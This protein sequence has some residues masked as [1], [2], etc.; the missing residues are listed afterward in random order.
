LKE[1]SPA[2]NARLNSLSGNAREKS[3][4]KVILNTVGVISAR[5]GLNILKLPQ[6]RIIV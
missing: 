5:K 6:K 2:A 4:V 1:L 3:V